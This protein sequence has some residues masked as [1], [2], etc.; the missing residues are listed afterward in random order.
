MIT[1]RTND[2][3]KLLKNIKE[4]IINGTITSWTIDTDNDFSISSGVWRSKAWIRSYVD[5]GNN[6]MLRFGIIESRMYGMSKTI[7][8]VFSARFAE[9]L[10]TY[11][12]NEIDY[13]DI[14]SLLV[15]DVDVA[16]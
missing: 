6:D 7:Y 10:L 14:S 3:T 16:R 13:V 2:A 8:A 12:D 9:M 1:I 11:F 15:R 4:S 5:D